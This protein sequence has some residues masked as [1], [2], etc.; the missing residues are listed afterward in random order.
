M[1]RIKMAIKAALI[2]TIVGLA[3]II[4][5]VALLVVGLVVSIVGLTI[6]GIVIAVVGILSLFFAYLTGKQMLHAIC[7]ECQKF[8][9]D[10]DTEVNYSFT[11][12]QYK[13]NYDNTNKFRDYTFYYTCTIE[14][15]HCG[16]TSTFEYKTNAK[17]EP[18]ANV[19]VD[20]YLKSTLKMKK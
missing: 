8:M 19:A 11:C 3:G 9:G 7:P 14:C 16:S 5:G 15:P 17:T 12:N 4:I 6:T 20:K 2:P 10:S 13:E 1:F 18:Q